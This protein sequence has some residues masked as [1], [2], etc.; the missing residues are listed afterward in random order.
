MPQGIFSVDDLRS[1]R[2]LNTQSSCRAAQGLT[3]AALVPASLC[4]IFALQSTAAALDS[5]A[6]IVE[7]LS[8]DS[9]ARV[10]RFKRSVQ[11]RSSSLTSVRRS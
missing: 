4:D 8:T 5:L 6:V 9:E 2:P 10:G 1:G 3:R 7:N 11:G